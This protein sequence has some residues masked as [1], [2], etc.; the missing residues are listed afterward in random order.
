MNNNAPNC[1][2]DD[3]P[4]EID[5]DYRQTFPEH[6]KCK[7]GGVVFQIVRPE[8]VCTVATCVACGKSGVI[9]EG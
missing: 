2:D 9:H 6:L 1:M 7:C 4:F 5:D 3:Y 8:F